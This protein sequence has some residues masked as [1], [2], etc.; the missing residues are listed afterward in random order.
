MRQLY[1][2]VLAAKL[3]T[4][5]CM[6]RN[7]KGNPTLLP[8]YKHK[9]CTIIMETLYYTFVSAYVWGHESYTILQASQNNLWKF[10]LSMEPWE[11]N[12]TYHIWWKEP[13]T[14]WAILVEPRLI[15]KSFILNLFLSIEKLSVTCY[16]L[17]LY[18]I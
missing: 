18:H 3:V 9:S 5:I 7:P 8:F 14:R 13:F 11:V 15:F 6:I 1:I 10:I 17:Q 2:K 16:F 12:M 4:W